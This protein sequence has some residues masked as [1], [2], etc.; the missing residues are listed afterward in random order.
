MIWIVTFVSVLSVI[1]EYVDFHFIEENDESDS[2]SVFY[3]VWGFFSFVFIIIYIISAV[4]FIMWFRRAYYNLHQKISDLSYTESWAAI[5]WFIPLANLVVPYV[6]MKDLYTKINILLQNNTVSRL[7]ISNVRIWWGLWIVSS[8][9]GSLSF[10]ASM[11]DLEEV[12]LVLSIID[13]IIAI[14][15]AIVTVR[16]IEDYSVSESEL[17]SLDIETMQVDEEKIVP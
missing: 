4:T 15:L 7:K 5:G 14:P 3:L 16:I 17:V 2:V 10:R 1:C 8:I 13:C 12:S 9:I 6:I 11:N